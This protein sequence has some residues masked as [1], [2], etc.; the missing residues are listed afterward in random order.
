VERAADAF[1]PFLA[2]YVGGM[3]AREMNFHFDVFARMGYEEEAVKIQDL[4]L[5]GHKDEAAAAVP[6]SMV[7]DIALIGPKEKIRDDLEAWRESIAT[8]LLVSGDPA[9]LETM[10]E[11]VS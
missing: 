10:A 1:R 11:L 7:E 3:G 8:S 6:T 5:D 9:T 4:Y 2:L